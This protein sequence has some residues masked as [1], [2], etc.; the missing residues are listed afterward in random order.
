VIHYN[1]T[2]SFKDGVAD[3]HALQRVAA[4]LRGLRE[5]ALIHEFD[6]RRSDDGQHFANIRFL[7]REQFNRPFKE[8][9]DI[10]IHAGAHGFMIENVAQFTVATIEEPE[11]V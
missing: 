3:E 11:A 2:F 8:V 4:F 9:A 6:I 1:V 5:R 7:N 10:G